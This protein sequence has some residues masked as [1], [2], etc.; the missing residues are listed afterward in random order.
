MDIKTLFNKI[1]KDQYLNSAHRPGASH[2]PFLLFRAGLLLLICAFISQSCAEEKAERLPPIEQRGPNLVTSP[3]I[4]EE[5]NTEILAKESIGLSINASSLT[6]YFR[7]NL[8]SAR[9]ECR[10]STAVVFKLCAA[11]DKFQFAG[12]QHGQKMMLQVRAISPS[13]EVDPTPEEIQFTVDHEK[14]AAPYLQAES[15]MRAE[16]VRAKLVRQVSGQ[17]ARLLLGPVFQV[18]APEFL[19]VRNFST[20]QTITNTVYAFSE[21]LTASSTV[22]GVGTE[23]CHR[24][25]EQKIETAN[26]RS[27]CEATPSISNWNQAYGRNYPLNHIELVGVFG[28]TTFER[29]LAAAYGPWPDASEPA[30]EASSACSGSNGSGRAQLGSLA[31]SLGVRTADVSWCWFGSGRKVDWWQ[32]AISI[33]TGT[34]IDAPRIKIV[35]GISSARGIYSSDQFLQRMDAFLPQLMT[36]IGE[37]AP[38]QTQQ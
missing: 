34:G 17:E 13:G 6:V 3:S 26:Q 33:A 23:G 35:Y 1:N 29:I 2:R 37:T 27:Y 32:A 16:E 12:M 11:G 7:S 24:D 8:A 14:G 5:L 21:I 10:A 4:K 30:F 9:F 20:S 28:G 25:W 18:R 22:A 15:P 31:A 38:A 19:S 36:A